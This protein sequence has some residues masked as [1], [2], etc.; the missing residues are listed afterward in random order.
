M[1]KEITSIVFISIL[2][3]LVLFFIFGVALF[4]YDFFNF[5]SAR[6]LTASYFSLWEKFEERKNSSF[7]I[8]A[9]GDIMLDRGVEYK[10]KKEGKGNFK[11]PFAEIANELKNADILFGNLEGPISNRGIKSGSIYSFRMDPKAVEGLQ[12]AGFNILSLANNHMFDYGRIALRD[13]MNILEKSN[14][15]YVG[16]GVD[17]REA[18]S[19][20]IIKVKNTKVAFLAYTNLGPKSWR[21]KKNVS[22]IAWINEGYFSQIREEIKKAKKQADILI[23][24]LHSGIE[25]ASFPDDF[26]KRFAKLCI[27]SGADVVIGHH[28]HVIQPLIRYKNGWIA[29][30]LGNFVFDQSFSSETMKGLLLEITVK[31]GRI[32]E[33][34]GRE[35]KISEDFQPSL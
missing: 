35:I 11:F 23:V 20:K 16:A 10:I 15:K 33:V 32:R 17:E 14:I 1:K 19:F 30:S 29:Y 8:K 7:T 25:Y 13:T 18:Y 9:V 31:S 26:Q 2:V 24:S 12:Y 27:D 21:A 3:S 34:K 5:L 6:G 4:F 22:G 28:P